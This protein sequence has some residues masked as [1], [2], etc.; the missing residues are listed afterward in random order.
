M[1]RESPKNVDG[2]P[3][4]KILGE[5][6][7]GIVYQV[8]LPGR[9]R[10]AALK[11]FTGNLTPGDILKFKREFG[12]IARCRHSGIVSVY[13]MGEEDSRPY[14]LMEFIR[15]LPLDEALRKGLRPME[16][17]PLDRKDRLADAIQEILETLRYLH[18]R[19]IVHRDIKPGNLM[20]TEDGHVK[21]LDF[22]MAWQHTGEKD[23][24]QGGT[25]GYQAPEMILGKAVDPRSDL[26]SLGVCLYEIL[27]GV[28]PFGAF[29]GWQ[30]LIDRQI[31]GRFNRLGIMN[32]AYGETWEFFTSKLMHASPM[33]RFQSA[34]QALVDLGRLA[35]IDIE[36]AVGSPP[37][38]LEWGLL[39]SEWIG[40]VELLNRSA[41]ALSHGS[42]VHFEAP[43]GAGRTRW[44]QEMI[45]R[46]GSFEEIIHT[47]CMIDSLHTWVS[48]FMDAVSTGKTGTRR[49]T[50]PPAKFVASYL[51]A[52]S[53][54]QEGSPERARDR[55]IDSVL[56]IVGNLPESFRLLLCVDNR[57]HS[58]AISR[59]LMDALADCEK[60]VVL[61]AGGPLDGP[62]KETARVVQ[63]SPALVEDLTQLVDQRLGQENAA[64]SEV[65]ARI[66]ELAEHRL[67]RA[68]VFLS[69]WY[70]NGQLRYATDH[71][72]MQTAV[73]KSRLSLKHPDLAAELV[74]PPTGKRRMPGE[75]RL[76]REIL[77]LVAAC[78]QPAT[79]PL[80]S[81]IF[82]ARETLIL[83]V[84]DRLIRTGW[85]IEATEVDGVTYRYAEPIVK[86]HVY[87]SLSPFHKRYLHRRIAETIQ[88]TGGDETGEYAW[89]ISRSDNSL[90]GLDE[91]EKNAAAARDRY[92]NENALQ[93]YDGLLER[94]DR[95]NRDSVDVIMGP[96]D[97]LLRFDGV[98]HTVLE[99]SARNFRKIEAAQRDRKRLEI[100]RSLGNIYGR[101]GDYGAA[102]D[103]FQH[104][105]AGARDIGDRK[106]EG[107]A[108]RF[109]GQV[110][111]YQR[112]LNESEKYFK[113]SLDIRSED[114][115]QE[116]IADCLNALGVLAQQNDDLDSALDYFGR[117]LEI[118]EKL[119]DEKGL[120]YIKNNIANIYYSKGLLKEALEEFQASAGVF[121]RLG[122]MLGLAYC[123][124][125]IGGVAIE[126]EKFDEAVVVLEEA[127]SIRRKMQDLQDMGH[128][129]WQ[130][131]TAYDGLGHTG[132]ARESIKEA[133]EV[134][135]KVNLTEDAAECR[136]FL[137]TL[138]KK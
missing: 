33:E 86:T 126:L 120:V 65:V 90:A 119:N 87:R 103:A 29:N 117:S 72:T 68:S 30:D 81:K 91:I 94:I 45:H 131:A 85:L 55:F 136:Q 121:R 35:S 59:R 16:P 93:W 73:N 138:K 19:R 8:R 21:L 127:L 130:L 128:S 50:N 61:S 77:R 108:L 24:R 40:D 9:Q 4:V 15:G 11:L 22:G 135:E 51:N 48:R 129:L 26:Y 7:A 133:I 31:N 74:K 42:S 56:A 2:Y 20:M 100:Y 44:I 76:D 53:N 104:V 88:R 3:V 47:D 114:D 58:D 46:S 124:Y 63:W 80:I 113:E 32:K 71:W 49:R 78:D 82:A 64:A 96:E 98:S 125:N 34:G 54:L 118:K 137:N 67:G 57:D 18:G 110:L 107:D 52:D 27:A 17:L 36:G 25:A 122:D 12:A 111:F 14:I 89:H 41:E 38:A 70:R 116:G 66:L 99:D 37:D 39:E 10:H 102:F 5:G 106:L 62:E 1:T 23:D 6:A 28:N 123:L 79:F 95:A 101:T 109:I 112:K 75:D 84:L 92:E 43:H 60:I 83:E 97:W 13:G 69:H 132:K 115:D 105:L 134:L